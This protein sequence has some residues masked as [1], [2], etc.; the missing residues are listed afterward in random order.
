MI[1]PYV[2]VGLALPQ[3][4]HGGLPVIDVVDT[5]TVTHAAA[6]EAHKLRTQCCERLCKVFAKS[7]FASL[8]SVHGEEAHHIDIV[9]AGLGGFH[10]EASL[11]GV[12]VGVD[13]DGPGVRDARGER[14]RDERARRRHKEPREPPDRVPVDAG[15][16]GAH[17][18]Y[19]LCR[20]HPQAH[21]LGSGRP[22]AP[23]D[24]KVRGA[25]LA[26]VAQ[27]IA[28]G[29][30]ALAS[31]GS[32]YGNGPAPRGPCRE[33]CCFGVGLRVGCAPTGK[34]GPRVRAQLRHADT[35]RV[36]P[37]C[38][39]PSTCPRAIIYSS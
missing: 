33:G 30:G 14:E 34:D 39:G 26:S 6:R 31:L 7:V 16:V 5:V 29:G 38:P 21:P 32:L 4:S 8:I 25:S 22:C 15:L 27:Q 24:S 11:G 17:R 19:L 10:N 35:R 1:V 9:A 2:E 13:V 28:V 3:F 12:A 20:M 23:D 37:Q 36:A 18:S